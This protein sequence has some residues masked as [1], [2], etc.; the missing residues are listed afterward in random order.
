MSRCPRGYERGL[1]ISNPAEDIG[2]DDTADGVEVG[3]LKNNRKTVVLLRLGGIGRL[4]FS[5]YT[6]V[7]S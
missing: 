6:A 1:S 5:V 4:A 3:D 2:Y 7:R